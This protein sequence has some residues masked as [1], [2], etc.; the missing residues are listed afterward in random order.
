MVVP[1][2]LKTS[3]CAQPLRCP[4]GSR[5]AAAEA[6]ATSADEEVVCEGEKTREERDAELRGEAVSLDE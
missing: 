6:V 1:G 4:S 3:A 2:F 5:L